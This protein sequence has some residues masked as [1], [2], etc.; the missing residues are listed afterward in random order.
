M[1]SGGNHYWWFNDL[2]NQINPA[3]KLTILEYN[4][5]GSGSFNATFFTGRNIQ[6]TQRLGTL[7]LWLLGGAVTAESTT[8]KVR[9][10]ATQSHNYLGQCGALG[11]RQELVSHSLAD[12]QLMTVNSQYI[13]IE[14]CCNICGGQSSTV[15]VA[16]SRRLQE[17]TCASLSYT[18]KTGV[19]LSGD[20]DITWAETTPAHTSDDNCCTACSA[21]PGCTAFS[22][23]Q[24]KCYLT[25]GNYIETPYDGA[26]AFMR[27]PTAAG[28]IVGAS[29]PPPPDTKLGV[30]MSNGFAMPRGNYTA[31]TPQA[32]IPSN[33]LSTFIVSL[34]GAQSGSRGHLCA[35]ECVDRHSLSGVQYVVQVSHYHSTND[36]TVDNVRCYC[37]ASDPRTESAFAYEEYTSDFFVTHFE[38]ANKPPS[39]PPP[40][41]PP[42][43]VA[44]P[45]TTCA[46]FLVSGSACL[47]YTERK[48]NTVDASEASEAGASVWYLQ[49]SP[50]PPSPPPAPPP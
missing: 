3:S 46:G 11:F 37:Y 18:E 22:V 40:P 32:A 38:I 23:Y 35:S 34:Q 15:Q 19:Y 36:H 12:M 31:G 14:D 49:P 50:P 26:R 6:P 10:D 43:A 20:S 41:L 30:A 5:V 4:G 8:C 24:G 45:L 7:V 42:P 33:R 29:P 16:D 39:P 48:T 1:A 9:S 2:H 25:M 44:P 21:A 47:F 17:E 13:S 27:V 28:L